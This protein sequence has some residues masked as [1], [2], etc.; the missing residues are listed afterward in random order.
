[1]ELTS[2]SKINRR[3]STTTIFLTP[4][5]LNQDGN[6]EKCFNNLRYHLHILLVKMFYNTSTAPPTTFIARKKVT[7]ELICPYCKLMKTLPG[8][9]LLLTD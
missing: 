1:M 4:L 2:V 9:K 6:E 8:I 3:S 7:F 5:K